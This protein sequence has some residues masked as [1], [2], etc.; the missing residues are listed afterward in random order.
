MQF[1]FSSGPRRVSDGCRNPKTIGNHAPN[2]LYYCYKCYLMV[3]K[4]LAYTQVPPL[5]SRSFAASI[6]AIVTLAPARRALIS[7]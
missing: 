2:V 5:S 7:S 6:A 1:S 3:Y 4:L